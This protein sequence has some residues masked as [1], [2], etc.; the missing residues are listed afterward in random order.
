MITVPGL[1]KTAYIDWDI[2]FNN[3]TTSPEFLTNVHS[4]LF[5]EANWGKEEAFDKKLAY[6]T[7]IDW[8]GADMPYTARYLNIPDGIHLNTTS[9]LL[10]IIERICTKLNAGRIVITIEVKQSHDNCGVAPIL[11]VYIKSPQSGTVELNMVYDGVN[12]IEDDGYFTGGHIDSDTE[13]HVRIKNENNFLTKLSK[14][15][16]ANDITEFFIPDIDF[17]VIFT[18]DDER[19]TNVKNQQLLDLPYIFIQ[20]LKLNGINEVTKKISIEKTTDGETVISGD[21]IYQIY[22]SAQLLNPVN[23]YWSDNTNV[24]V[25]ANKIEYRM[26]NTVNKQ[27]RIASYKK[28]EPVKDYIIDIL[29]RP[30]TYYIYGYYTDIN[31]FTS[32]YITLEV[33]DSTNI[34]TGIIITDDVNNILNDLYSITLQNDPIEK[35][36]KIWTIN[37]DSSGKIRKLI[38]DVTSTA[39]LSITSTPENIYTINGKTVTYNNEGNVN[40]TAS[41]DSFTANLHVTV[42]QQQGYYF[43]ILTN[44]DSAYITASNYTDTSIEGINKVFDK[45][46]IVYNGVKS[47]NN[48]GEYLYVIL[49]VGYTLEVTGVGGNNTFTTNMSRY[50]N[51]IN[52]Y[53]LLSANDENCIID[54]SYILYRST[55]MCHADVN[56]N[57]IK[58]A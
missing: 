35:S 55:Q 44:T 27:T 47:I 4:V 9:E 10:D 12:I 20:D 6:A 40:M 26:Y 5:D 54:N 17:K 50:V 18:P 19:Y 41:Y 49:P 1:E 2:N 48:N 13:Y 24:Q 3:I 52:V 25:D 56:I 21:H 11:D 29:R 58:K 15:T 28:G 16:S 33:T 14:A 57:I 37:R 39:T 36:Y 45:N 23:I 42:N 53:S 31:E 22:D 51:D 38:K 46:S 8:N 30:G 34:P 32:N 43:G 7:S